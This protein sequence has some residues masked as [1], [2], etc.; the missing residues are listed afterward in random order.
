M[1]GKGQLDGRVDRELPHVSVSF[2]QGTCTC[3]DR[4]IAR[5]YFVGHSGE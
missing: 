3:S 5:S 4:D 2:L 1:T